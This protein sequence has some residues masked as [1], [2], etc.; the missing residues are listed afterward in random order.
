MSID[1]ETLINVARKQQQADVVIRNGQ[2]VNVF[3][4]EIYPGGVA[5]VGD[6]IAAT[7]EVDDYIGPDTISIDAE[8]G[9]ITPGLIDG[10]VHI[11]S[12]M[13]S[14]TRF[15]E[16][17]LMHGTTSVMSDLH[18]VAVVGG[19]DTVREIL[20]EAEQSLL[21]IYFVIPSHVPFSPGFETTG[22]IVG[23]VEVSCNL[24]PG[25]G[26]SSLESHGYCPSSR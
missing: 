2:I 16:L 1:F 7:G 4:G 25:H 24:C 3:S 13:L 21:K 11:E 23:P 6:K 15:S 20:E 17:A 12:S 9:Y 10:H 26:R 14:V 19:I 8:T 22:A 18:E 5:I